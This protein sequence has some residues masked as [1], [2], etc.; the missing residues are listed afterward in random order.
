MG[1]VGDLNKYSQF[2]AAN[3]MEAAA[4][5]PSGEASSGIGM[6]MGFAMANQMANTMNNQSANN[7]SQNNGSMPP[8]LPNAVAYFIAVNGKQEG[9]LDMNVLKAYISQGTI[10]KETLVWKQGMDKWTSA[11]DVAEISSL[12]GMVPPPIPTA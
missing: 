11:N 5:N 4:K 1:V 9:P 12:F 7:A 10:T 2:Q 6:G 3:A 8:P